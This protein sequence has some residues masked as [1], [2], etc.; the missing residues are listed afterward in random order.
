M[1]EAKPK[2]KR[3]INT[4]QIAYLPAATGVDGQSL[5]CLGPPLERRLHI[6]V[7]LS[8][9]PPVSVA[10]SPDVSL[11]KNTINTK[12]MTDMKHERLYDSHYR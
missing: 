3:K 8:D 11:V 7:D 10:L 6:S 2:K 1:E 9:Q 12:D 5:P 4:V